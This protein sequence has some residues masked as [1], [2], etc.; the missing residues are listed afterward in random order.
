MYEHFI[1]VGPMNGPTLST[2]K[3]MPEALTEIID[4]LGFCCCAIPKADVN[5]MIRVCPSVL[6]LCESRMENGPRTRVTESSAATLFVPSSVKTTGVRGVERQ[7]PLLPLV[8]RVGL[9]PS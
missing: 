3:S 6:K 1:P 4:E 8:T 2:G 5:K 9:L 7:T